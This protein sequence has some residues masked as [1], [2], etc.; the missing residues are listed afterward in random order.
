MDDPLDIAREV[1]PGRWRT[2]GKDTY[3]RY[4]FAQIGGFRVQFCLHTTG[5]WV[6]EGPHEDLARGKD[7]AAVL[8]VARDEVIASVA[9]VVR[10]VGADLVTAA[11]AEDD[12]P[13][14]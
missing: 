11:L 12:K 1:W 10:A 13:H 14:A 7:L 8:A 2:L 4:A 3:I 5:E 9:D 6:V